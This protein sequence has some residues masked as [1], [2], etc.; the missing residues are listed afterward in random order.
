MKSATACAPNVFPEQILSASILYYL[1]FKYHVLESHMMECSV[2]S[3]LH[4][5]LPS[6]CPS[7]ITEKVLSCSLQNPSF[8][9]SYAKDEKSS[10]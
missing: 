3:F 5:D 4:K 10:H 8:K 7:P 1:Q 9:I 2:E 6:Q